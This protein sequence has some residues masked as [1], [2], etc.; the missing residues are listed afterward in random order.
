MIGITASQQ[1]MRVNS[2]TKAFT[3]ISNTFSFFT[4]Y[5]K[6]PSWGTIDPSPFTFP[7]T[8]HEMVR[9]N[10]NSTT[11]RMELWE[12]YTIATHKHF[13]L[14]VDGVSYNSADATITILD[15]GPRTRIDWAI[16]SNI[17]APDGSTHNGSITQTP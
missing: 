7:L 12:V 3:I 2:P 1:M 11:L 5:L 16:G 14:V 17:F 10:S 13:T 8:G 6:S 15:S 4:G 9:L